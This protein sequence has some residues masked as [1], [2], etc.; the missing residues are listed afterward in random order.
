MVWAGTSVASRPGEFYAPGSVMNFDAYASIAS[1]AVG[2]LIL[3]T[4]IG[5][6]WDLATYPSGW[7]LV[8]QGRNGR[9]TW[10]VV[11]G[12]HTGA[13]SYPF[14]WSGGSGDT[15]GALIRSTVWTDPRGMVPAVIDL[16]VLGSTYTQ[17]IPVLGGTAHPY[18]EPGSWGLRA[19]QLTGFAVSGP[20]NAYTSPTATLDSGYVAASATT[21]G[22][23][24]LWYVDP[25]VVTQSGYISVDSPDTGD[26]VTLAVGLQSPDTA[27]VRIPVSLMRDYY[28]ADLPS[29]VGGGSGAEVLSDSSDGTYIEMSDTQEALLQFGAYSI[30]SGWTV[31]TW[32]G[33]RVEFRA[34]Q[35][36]AGDDELGASLDFDYYDEGSG[37]LS[38]GSATIT[39][40][41]GSLATHSTWVDRP[42][43][44]TAAR[45][46]EGLF[47]CDVW[48]YS[49]GSIVQIAKAE[50]V[51]T[52]R[53]PAT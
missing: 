40:L 42:E 24:S 33:A 50:L 43:R 47:Q 49:A 27:E 53:G 34:R 4:I 35:A 2:D 29:V 18:T 44:L 17:W 1:E 26:W 39:G 5:F 13:A 52:I 9:V 23:G 16:S 31:D 20:I 7:T 12:Y 10:A 25:R 21:Y 28:G 41:T 19:M 22:V 48:N 46:A 11:Y 51:L 37:Y 6:D 36:G 45:L 15:T 3:V 8:E 32:H 30:P 38:V 14:S